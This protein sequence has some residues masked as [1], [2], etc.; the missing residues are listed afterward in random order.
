[1]AATAVECWNNST[2]E[3]RPGEKEIQMKFLVQPATGLSIEHNRKTFFFFFFSICTK[4]CRD[5][6]SDN[7]IEK[8]LDF[9]QRTIDSFVFHNQ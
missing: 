1:M 5:I 4:K 7:R 2:D 8:P 9:K 6:D 3:G